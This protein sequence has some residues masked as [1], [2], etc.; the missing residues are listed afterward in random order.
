[1]TSPSAAPPPR[2]LE[3][4]QL[5]VDLPLIQ[6]LLRLF[7]KAARAH[8]LYLPNNPVYKSA[9]DALRAGFLPIWEQT[10]ELVLSFTENEVKYGGETAL[11]ERSKGSDSLPWIFFK[12][13]VRELRFLRGFDAEELAK[14]LDILQRVRKASPDEDDLLTLLWQGDFTFLRYRYVDMTVEPTVPLAEGGEALTEGDEL[15]EG[16]GRTGRRIDP[17]T[18]AGGGDD[19]PEETRAGVVS[20]SDFDATLYF[21]DE[22]EIEYLQTEVRREY[23]TDLR[24]NVVA[25]LLDILEQQPDATIREEVADVLDNFMLH[26]LSAGQFRNVAYLLREAQVASQRAAELQPPVRDRLTQL[27]SRLSA[28]DALSQML[29]SIDESAEPPTAAELEDLFE[30]LRPAALETV[31]EWLGRLQTPRVRPLLEQA[32]ARL[33]SQNTGELVKLIGSSLR[34]VALEATRRAGAVKTPAAVAPLAKLLAHGDV[35]LRTAAI[36]ALSEIGTPGAMQALE[37]GVEDADREVRIATVRAIQTRA[38]RAGLPKL[39]AAVHGR[40]IRSAD[41]SEKMALF[42]AYGSMCGDAGVA[43]LDT[44][45]NGKSMFGRREEPEIRACAAMALGRVGTPAAHEALQRAA[46]EKDVVVR[47]AVSRALRGASA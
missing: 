42:E 3:H 11:E 26:M 43:A 40:A 36:Q 34:A 24:Q 1:V 5:A 6:E 7:G 15:S 45:L 16:G 17:A 12:D 18:Y 2:E 33:A 41:L 28:P 22:K 32:A 8:Q 27:P 47:N 21:L 38:Y 13:G 29:Q 31:F 20:M 9:Q 19:E 4:A 14:L 46:T 10:D 37:R 39:E 25:M 44:T 35:E 30:Q 23:E